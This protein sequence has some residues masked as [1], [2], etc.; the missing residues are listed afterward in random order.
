MD[1]LSCIGQAS[2][3][4]VREANRILEPKWWQPLKWI[5]VYNEAPLRI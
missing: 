2:T 3:S 5:N 1:I 4:K